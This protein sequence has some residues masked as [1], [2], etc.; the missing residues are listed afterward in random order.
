MNRKLLLA[1]CALWIVATGAWAQE[2][3]LPP[4]DCFLDA[5][6]D[7]CFKPPPEQQPG[8][9][10]QEYPQQ[11]DTGRCN[12]NVCRITVKA[13]GPCKISVS[14]EFTFISQEGVNILWELQAAGNFAF[15][16]A[17]GIEFK[18]EY[19]PTYPQQFVAGRRLDPKT[20]HYFDLNTQPGSF[21]YSIN[22][23]NTRTG[24]AC[25]LDPGLVNDWP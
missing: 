10:P 2:I 16:E 15:D 12:A 21:R 23:Y 1:A 11:M 13:V 17:R 25:S 14:P 3:I 22:V 18:G 20:W 7:G 8:R 6:S 5:T 19:N 4:R 9:N 24:Q